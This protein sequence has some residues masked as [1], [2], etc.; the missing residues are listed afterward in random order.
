MRPSAVNPADVGFPTPD[1][2][3]LFDHF[4]REHLE[5][6]GRFPPDRLAVT[7]SPRLDTI[8]AASRAV[9]TVAR[10]ELREALGA[11]PETH[12]I[13]V[14]SKFTQI[15]SAF[16]ALVD[17]AAA[18]PAVLLVVKPHPAEGANPYLEA[19]AGAAHVRI[20]PPDADLGTLTTIASGLVTVNSTSA[21]EAMLLDVPALVVAL[22]NNLTPFVDVGAMAG[23][24]TLAAIGPALQ[25]LLYDHSMRERLAEARR[26]FITRYGIVAD[27]GAAGRAAELIVGLTKR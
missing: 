12:V 13:V 2:T 10:Q 11:R 4:A 27:G 22:P 1:R 3:L 24:P 19:A 23:A 6:E 26:A 17:A 8:V 16:R 21:I 25:G 5:R 18:M 20:A 9:D 7:G 14:A 15:A